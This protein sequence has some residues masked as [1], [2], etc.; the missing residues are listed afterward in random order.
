M[1]ATL[2][3]FCDLSFH[4]VTVHKIIGPTEHMGVGQVVIPVKLNFWVSTNFSE[5]SVSLP[6]KRRGELL[7]CP[8]TETSSELEKL[9]QLYALYTLLYPSA[10]LDKIKWSAELTQV[11]IILGSRFKVVRQTNLRL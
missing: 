8:D 2:L 1:S 4:E 6:M 5:D 10:F 7:Q 3:M 9:Q 11:F